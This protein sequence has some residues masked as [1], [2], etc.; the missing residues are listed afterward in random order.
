[1]KPERDYLSEHLCAVPAFR[2][3]LR[4]VEA[5]QMAALD[6]PRPILDLGCGDGHFAQAAFTQPLDVGLDPSP[7][8]IAAA[9]TR[10]MHRRLYVMDSGAMAFNAGSFASVLSNSVVEHIPDLEAT[11]RETYRVLKP[12]GMFVFTTPS[13]HFADYL[14]LA[15]FFRR[16]GL[17]GLSKQYGNYFN[18]LSRHYRT[19]SPEVWQARLEKFGFKVCESHSYFSRAAMRLFDLAHYYSAPTLVYKKLTGRWII[20]PFRAN[21][22]LIEPLWRHY[23]S[24]PPV[25]DGAYLFFRCE[26]R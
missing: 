23:Y 16:I 20:A 17:G 12:G 1:M 9:Q 24:E 10:R 26:R 13:S 22:A 21:F 2:A 19:D 18:R 6:W 4:G 25:N 7:Q 14:F 3:L 8:A 5:R 11:L 15:D